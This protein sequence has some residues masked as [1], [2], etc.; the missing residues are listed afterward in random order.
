MT[1]S[2]VAPNIWF[3]WVEN[4]V[5]QVTS[6]VHAC[7]SLYHALKT[8][9]PSREIVECWTTFVIWCY[10]LWKRFQWRVQLCG[11]FHRVDW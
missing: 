3:V 11:M 7:V 1:F 6:F 9:L 8:N 10:T 4:Q 5:R 2:R